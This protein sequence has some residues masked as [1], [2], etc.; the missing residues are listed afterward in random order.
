MTWGSISDVPIP[1]TTTATLR[2]RSRRVPR[3]HRTLADSA[4]EHE[5]PDDADV[6]HEHRYSHALMKVAAITGDDA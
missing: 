1:V 3:E 6:G 4:V 5:H 2:D